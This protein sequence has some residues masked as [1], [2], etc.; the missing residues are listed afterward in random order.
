MNILLELFSSFLEAL[1]ELS[2]SF[3][4]TDAMLTAWVT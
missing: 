1:R 2:I 4:V 3:S